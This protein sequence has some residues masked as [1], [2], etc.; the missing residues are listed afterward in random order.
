MLEVGEKI[1]E[2]RLPDQQ[3]AER[4]LPDLLGRRGGII[5]FY[6]RDSTPGCT[7]EANDFQAL[8]HEFDRL[9]LTVTGISKDSVASHSRF[10]LKQGLTFTLLSDQDG[11]ACT[12]FG[13]WQEKTS[14][15][16]TSMGI[17]R[18]TFVV[19]AEGVVQKIYRAVKTAGHGA[20]VLA[21]A[22]AAQGGG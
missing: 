4:R 12:R 3:G 2:I 15:G 5:Y 9:G 10:C 17:V 7:V 18:S 8:L 22:G 6:P 1:P 19:D 13:V 20:Q 11:E 21:D 14:Y 16:R